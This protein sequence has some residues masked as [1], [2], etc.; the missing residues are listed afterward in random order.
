MMV[1]NNFDEDFKKEM[2]RLILKTIIVTILLI[3]AKLFGEGFEQL[4]T[5]I[6]GSVLVNSKI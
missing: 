5:V 1:K 3:F 6:F 2:I 4:V